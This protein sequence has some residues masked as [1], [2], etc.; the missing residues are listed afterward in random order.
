MEQE[1]MRPR[2]GT[3]EVLRAAEILRKYRQGPPTPSRPAD[4]W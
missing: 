4:G 2:I 1:V 3:Q